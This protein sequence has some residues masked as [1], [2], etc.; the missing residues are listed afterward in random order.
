MIKIDENTYNKMPEEIK[1]CFMLL[2]N[3]SKDEVVELFPESNGAGGSTP[4]SKITGYGKNISDGSYEYYGG[5]RNTFDSGSGSVARFFYTAKASQTERNW[6][7]D[8]FESKFTASAEFRPNHMEKAIEGESGNPYGRWQPK[9]NIHPTVKPIDL[10]RY[11]VRLVTPP[12]GICLD[13]YLGS[14]TTA[15]A[16]K[17]EGF[18]YI[19]CEL[20]EEYVKIAEARIDGVVVYDP[21]IDTKV[22]IQESQKEK[23]EQELGIMNIFDFL[24]DE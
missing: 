9:R 11:L 5:D 14:G 10:M 16:C 6:G 24:G 15:V 13:P 7:L 1:K 21:N 22:A 17:M 18:N 3:K 12:N 23:K 2:P 4:Q 20:E 19:G 8:G